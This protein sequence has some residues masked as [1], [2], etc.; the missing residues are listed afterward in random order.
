MK[1]HYLLE[2]DRKKLQMWYVV[3]TF[4]HMLR[5][6]PFIEPNCIQNGEMAKTTVFTILS[7]KGL[8]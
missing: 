4:S 2:I 3:L 5:K 1:L 6:V 7:A 8:N